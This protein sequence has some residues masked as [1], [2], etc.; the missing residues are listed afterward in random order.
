MT[1]ALDLIY[2][3][4]IKIEQN[5]TIND[6]ILIDLTLKGTIKSDLIKNE[7]KKIKLYVLR[8]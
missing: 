4:S 6:M 7:N 1:K 8:T 5:M 2:Y 3:D